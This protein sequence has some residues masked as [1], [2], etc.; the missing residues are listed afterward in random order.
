MAKSGDREG[1]M[2]S[3]MQH[4][5][6]HTDRK[7]GA[8]EHLFWLIDKHRPLH[9]T[10]TG[11]VV[12]KTDVAAWRTALD[13]LQRRN[14]LMSA[15]I[16]AAEEG[17]FFRQRKNARIPLRIVE[18]D[19]G[20]SW[21][22]EV[23]AELGAPFSEKDS[24]LIRAVLIHADG[25]AAIT[26]AAHHS[27]ADGFSLAYAIRDILSTLAGNP[28]PTLPQ[29]PSEDEL[30]DAGPPEPIP[31]QYAPAADALPPVPKGYHL[32]DGSNPFVSSLS[33]P[34]QLTAQL[35]ARAR[36]ESTTVHCALATALTF[37]ARKLSTA[38]ST[39]PIRVWSPVNMRPVLNAGEHC[40]N[41]LG[42][43][44]SSFGLE[45]D[46]FWDLARRMG[47][48]IAPAKTRSGLHAALSAVRDFISSGPDVAG[49]AGF[50]SVAFAHEA[51]LTNLGV[52]PF[53]IQYGPLRL[54]R[55]WGPCILPDFED[56]QSVGVATIGG[57]ACLTHSS[58][59]PILGLLEE[60]HTK[61]LLA[62]V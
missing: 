12:G 17:P 24:P 25:A 32:R 1:H 2:G 54:Q 9:F 37:A 23:A 50:A 47:A 7:L 58:Y 15:A 28:P 22:A 53:P 56:M 3:V 35:R 18:G 16:E 48:E 46:A 39:I 21:Q 5:H 41:Y 38:W 40:G 33:L 59:S 29:T 52:L 36:A 60:M 11:H 30:F 45:T 6:V 43:A 49:A 13:A 42:S 62:T 51:V 55:V 14:A 10:M 31:T 57:E 34:Q 20:R 19:P 26:L 27:I 61:L 44:S 8:L 4:G